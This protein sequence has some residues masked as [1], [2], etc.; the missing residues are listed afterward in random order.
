MSA[1]KS[2]SPS[3]L[4]PAGTASLPPVSRREVPVSGSKASTEL[5]A[6][7]ET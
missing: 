7:F 3:I 6:M 4:R 2:V 1:T 5:S